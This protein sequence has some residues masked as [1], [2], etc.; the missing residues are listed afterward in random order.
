[1]GWGEHA[2]L[3]SSPCARTVLTLSGALDTDRHDCRQAQNDKQQGHE[4]PSKNCRS[5]GVQAILHSFLSRNACYA[6]AC[7][8]RGG[9]GL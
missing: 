4:T 8:Q 6:G 1:M 5:T 2:R 3:S 9:F 7:C